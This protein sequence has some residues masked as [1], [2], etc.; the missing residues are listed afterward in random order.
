MIG[1]MGRDKPTLLHRSDAVRDGFT[2]A[3]LLGQLKRRELVKVARGS[4]LRESEYRDLDAGDRHL[5][6][7]HAA[8]HRKRSAAV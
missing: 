8:A 7:V 6:R 3:D 2:D 5:A 1:S 4:Y